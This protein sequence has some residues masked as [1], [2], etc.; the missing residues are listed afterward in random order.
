[1]KILFFVVSEEVFS[2]HVLKKLSR[3]HEKLLVDVQVVQ[4]EKSKNAKFHNCFTKKF[5]RDIIKSYGLETVSCPIFQ[6]KNFIFSRSKHNGR[7]K[8]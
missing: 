7:N 6:K 8:M 2:P 4:F 3:S 1:M 5:S